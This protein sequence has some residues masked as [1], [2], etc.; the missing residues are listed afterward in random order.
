MASLGLNELKIT[1][2]RLQSQLP[3]A[4]ELIL[5]G[6]HKKLGNSTAY[7]F[8]LHFFIV[9]CLISVFPESML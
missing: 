9:K 4:N 3:G 1:N 2:L 6:Q 8:K 5:T 7:L